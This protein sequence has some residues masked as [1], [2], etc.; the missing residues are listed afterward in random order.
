MSANAVCMYEHICVSVILL[1]AVW[2]FTFVE[3]KY[4]ANRFACK[5]TRFN[6]YCLLFSIAGVIS[7]LDKL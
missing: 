6:I 4:E 1:S 5:K 3:K 7:F 2:I